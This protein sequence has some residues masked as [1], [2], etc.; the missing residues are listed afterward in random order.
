[1]ASISTTYENG[2]QVMLTGNNTIWGTVVSQVVD[3]SSGARAITC[4]V[5]IKDTNGA[6]NV[7]PFNQALL[8]AKS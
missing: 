1:M 7:L 5:A 4:L 3:G 6:T 8:S 2:D